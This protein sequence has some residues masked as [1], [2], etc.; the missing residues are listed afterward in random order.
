MKGWIALHRCL[1]N[2]AIW[3]SSTAEQKVILITLL[4]MAN[5]KQTEWEWNGK[6]FKARPGQFVTSIDSIKKAAGK[7]ISSQNV[8]TALKKFKTYGFLTD[9]STKTGRLITILNWDKYQDKDMPANKDINKDLTK[10][11]QRPNKELT[12]NNNVTM[13]QCNKNIKTS[14][15]K[16]FDI[17]SKEMMLA[18]ELKKRILKNNPKARVPDDMNKWAKIFD[19]MIRIDKRE[20]REIWHVLGYSQADGFWMSNILSPTKLREKYDQLYLRM[21]KGKKDGSKNPKAWDSIK[22]FLEGDEDGQ[23]GNS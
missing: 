3:H 13:K 22:E 9:E 17:D 12:P 6:Q 4:L 2:K 7:N 5:H 19:L 10:T 21:N 11:S 23:E 20:P 18:E 16:V 1:L 14:S 15:S 8:R